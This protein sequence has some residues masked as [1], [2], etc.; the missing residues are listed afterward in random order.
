MSGPDD[1]SSSLESAASES[2]LA[3][4]GSG[5]SRMEL[6]PF[7]SKKQVS[8]SINFFSRPSLD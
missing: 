6:L 3:L 8:K 7:L 5:A 4:W 1:D 2:S